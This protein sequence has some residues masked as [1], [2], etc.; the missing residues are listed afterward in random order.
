MTVWNLPLVFSSHDTGMSIMDGIAFLCFR[1]HLM[2]TENVQVL[3]ANTAQE[4]VVGTGPNNSSRLV[5][6]QV[7]WL[8]MPQMH[9]TC[10][11]EDLVVATCGGR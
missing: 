11:L 2:R 3:W 4:F 1:V 10:R 5:K 6:L 8:S 9:V 7:A